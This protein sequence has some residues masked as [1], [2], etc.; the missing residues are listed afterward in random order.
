M[1]QKDSLGRWFRNIVMEDGSERLF[2]KMDQ[3]DC[4]RRWIRSSE[5]Q[6]W[7]MVQKQKILQLL[8][9]TK[10]KILWNMRAIILCVKLQSSRPF[11]KTCKLKIA[12]FSSYWLNVFFNRSEIL[13]RLWLQGRKGKVTGT[14][15]AAH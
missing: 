12:D 4:H 2:L 15:S 9:R 7:K 1:D 13:P 10:I 11:L 8:Y 3:N 6:S 5:Q 14:V